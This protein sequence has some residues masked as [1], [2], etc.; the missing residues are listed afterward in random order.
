MPDDL[1]KKQSELCI[2][3]YTEF[4]AELDAMPIGGRFMPYDWQNLP[5]GM[6]WAPYAQMLD[7]YARELANIVNTLTH[8]VHRLR[9]WATVIAPLSNEDKMEAVHEF[10]DM[11]GSVAL[12]LPYVI[13]SR[14]AYAAAHLCHQA[15]KTKDPNGWK[16]EFPDKQ[17]LYL[18]DT[19]PLPQ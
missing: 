7:E 14:F 12:G 18:N 17:A 6:I 11:L 8:H 9:V 15:N 4:R 13:K 1:A 10:V 19:G 2:R 3:L 5:L 16:D